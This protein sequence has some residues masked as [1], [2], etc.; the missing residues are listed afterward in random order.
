MGESHKE[1]RIRNI[2]ILAS[3]FKGLTVKQ[4]SKKYNLTRSRVYQIIHAK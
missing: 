1:I 4:I 2:K 3:F